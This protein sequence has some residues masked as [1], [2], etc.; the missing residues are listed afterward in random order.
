MKKPCR[1]KTLE[2]VCISDMGC[3]RTG[4]NRWRWQKQGIL[5]IL[6]VMNSVP[7][8]LRKRILSQK[9]PDRLK[10]WLSLA[11]GCDSPEE[12]QEKSRLN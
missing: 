8:E 4:K 10:K 5:D 3:N 2:T 7:E 6:A 12:F 9:E 11:A 1:I